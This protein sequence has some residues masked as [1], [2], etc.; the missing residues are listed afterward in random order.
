MV[1]FA[2]FPT[3][4]IKIGVTDNLEARLPELAYDYGVDLTLL[5]TMP[6]DRS[7]KHE[8]HQRFADLRVGRTDQFEPG[9][10]LMDFIAGLASGR[11]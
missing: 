2:Q 1:Y 5:A 8:V 10:D 4:L 9:P 11:R 3:G 6:G 7:T